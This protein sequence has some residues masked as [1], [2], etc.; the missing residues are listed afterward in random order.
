MAEG[1]MMEG[2]YKVILADPPW[3]YGNNGCRGAAANEYSTMTVEDICALPIASL[4]ADDSVLLEWC[5]WPQLQEGLQVMKAWGFDYVT[6]FPW[7]KAKNISHDL[8]GELTFDVPYGVGFWARGC[9]EFVLIG[10]RG[11]PSPP[12]AGFIGLLSPNL[13]H[14]RKPDS[15]YHYAESLPGPYLELFARRRREGWDAFGNQV[16]GSIRL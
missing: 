14:S 5:T 13:S 4:A 9:T 11:K 10:K 7:V 8:W 12:K 3:A 6:G 1:G 2:K 16:E 15:I